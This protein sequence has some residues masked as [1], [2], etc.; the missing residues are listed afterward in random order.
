M[1]SIAQWIWQ[2]GVNDLED[3][4]I[5]SLRSKGQTEKIMKFEQSFGGSWNNAKLYNIC[6]VGSLEWKQKMIDIQNVFAEI[7]REIYPI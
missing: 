3:R 2:K 4:S 1:D 6:V 7:M 5:E